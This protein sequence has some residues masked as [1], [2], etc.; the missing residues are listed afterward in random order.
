MIVRTSRPSQRR[1]GT[2]LILSM[3]VLMLIAALTASMVSA[4]GNARKRSRIARQDAQAACLADAAVSRTVARLARD[5]AHVGETWDIPADQLE[6]VGP[7]RVSI[8]VV[9]PEG[10]RDDVRTVRVR[11]ELLGRSDLP[12]RSS[13]EVNVRVGRS[14]TGA[15]P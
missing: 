7:A 3:V 2:T 14:P 10:G 15:T 13:R 8:Q 4:I 11:A 12:T 5:P 6:G 1:R 9:R